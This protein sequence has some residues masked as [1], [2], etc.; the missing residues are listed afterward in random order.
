[1]YSILSWLVRVCS[2]TRCSIE[3]GKHWKYH[4]CKHTWWNDS[5]FHIFKTSVVGVLF[6][7]Y[8]WLQIPFDLFSSVKSKRT[9]SESQK[10]KLEVPFSVVLALFWCFW[11]FKD[12]SSGHQGQF[13][14]SNMFSYVIISHTSVRMQSDIGGGGAPC[15][16]DKIGEPYVQLS[17]V[18]LVGPILL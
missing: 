10:Q 15:V 13:S 11:T 6:W 7:S 17:L 8:L 14:T 12:I 2:D 5:L 18:R 1:M 3:I 9:A 4:I 16:L